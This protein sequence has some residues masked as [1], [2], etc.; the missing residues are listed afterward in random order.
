MSRITDKILPIVREWQQRPLEGI[1]AV[2]FLDAIHCHV[3]SEGRIVKK[4]VYIAIGIDLDVRKDVLGMCT[5]AAAPISSAC[6]SVSRRSSFVYRFPI[7]N[8]SLL[9]LFYHLSLAFWLSTFMIA[10]HLPGKRNIGA[11][12]VDREADSG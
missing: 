8:P 4:A 2:V 5:V 1:Y 7:L 6:F 9:V 10:L 3:R 12:C 11:F